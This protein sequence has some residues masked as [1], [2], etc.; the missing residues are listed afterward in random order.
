MGVFYKTNHYDNIL[1]ICLDATLLTTP[2][3]LVEMNTSEFHFSNL[4]C[5]FTGAFVL[6]RTS[7]EVSHKMNQYGKLLYIFHDGL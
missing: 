7:N 6:E 3:R 2:V 4:M 5:I 1:N